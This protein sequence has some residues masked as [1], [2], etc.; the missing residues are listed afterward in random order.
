MKT[1]NTKV[2]RRRFLSTGAIVGGVGALGMS[3]LL[4]SCAG[5]K[6]KKITDLVLPGKKAPDGVPLKAGLVGCGF[7]GT[8]AAMDFM[9]AGPNLTIVAAADVFQDKI[10]NFRKNLK[11]NK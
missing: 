2:D 10:D 8:A 1:K 7:R 6:E 5:E 3:T 11:E 9:N 4:S